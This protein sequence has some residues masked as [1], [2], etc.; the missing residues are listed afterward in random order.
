MRIT[1]SQAQR[2]SVLIS[3]LRWLRNTSLLALLATLFLLPGAQAATISPSSATLTSE[4]GAISSPSR[5]SL[6]STDPNQV[7]LFVAICAPTCDDEGSGSQADAVAFDSTQTGGSGTVAAI[8]NGGQFQVDFACSSPESCTV[9]V[10]FQGGSPGS[11]NAEVSYVTRSNDFGSSSTP[12]FISASA[13]L[14]GVSQLAP[15]EPRGLVQFDPTSYSVSE[16][17]ESVTVTAVREG[18]TNGEIVVEY[19][20]EDDSASAG[21]DYTEMSGTLTWPTGQGGRRTVTVPILADPDNE[22][23]DDEVFSVFLSEDSSDV[24]SLGQNTEARVTIVNVAPRPTGRIRFSAES[25]DARETDGTVTI[26]VQRVGGDR[27]EINIDYSTED[28]TAESGDDYEAASGELE[29]ANGDDS[30]RSFEVEILTDEEE[31]STEDFFVELSNEQRVRVNISDVPPD[32]PGSIQFSLDTYTVGE[33][34]GTV[35]LTAE[36]V[37]GSDG[38]LSVRFTTRD[39]SAESGDDYDA[40]NGTLT[41]D[42]GDDDP[43]TFEISILTDDGEEGTEDFFVDLSN[44]ESARVVIT[45][46]PP[47]N[48][49]FVEFSPVNYTALE[50]D[51][52]VTVT[53]TRQ[54]G[55]DGEITVVVTTVNGTAM[56]GSD[57]EAATDELTWLNG[58]AAP[59]SLTIELI[60][61]ENVE[62]T[63][64]FSVRMTLADEGESST[65]M[66]GNATTA[67]IEIEE[68]PVVDPGTL[69]FSSST[70]RAS[71]TDDTVDLIVTRTGGSDGAVAVNL[72]TSDGT[73][74]AGD[75]YE[76][77]Q[78]RLSW[79][80][81]ELGSKTLT[82]S[83]NEDTRSEPSETFTATLTLPSEQATST[84][85]TP[86]VATVTITDVAPPLE[87]GTVQFTTAAVSVDEDDDSVRLQISR[88]G[89]QDGAITMSVRSRNGSATEGEDFEFETVTVRWAD[90]DDGLRSVVVP[91]ELDNLDEPNETFRLSL[92]AD[93][94]NEQALGSPDTATVTIRDVSNPLEAGT[95]SLAEQSYQIREAQGTVTLAVNRTGGAQGAVSVQY[96]T[97]SG[98][99][100]SPEDFTESSGTL[101]WADGD[102]SP[103]QITVTV[104]ADAQ[105]EDDEQFEVTLS[106][107]E[108]PGN[109][110]LSLGRDSASVTIVDSTDPGQLQFTSETYSAG[111]S[112]GRVLFSVERIGGSDGPVSVAYQLREIT[113]SAGLDY[114]AVS[115]TLNWADGDMA[116]KTGAIQLLADREIETTETF[117]VILLNAQPVGDTQIVQ[118]LATMEIIDTTVPPND[119]SAV[120]YVLTIIS[121]DN[122]SFIPGDD[123]N[124]LVLQAS[125]EPPATDSVDNLAINWRVEPAGS[126][127]LLDGIQT[128]TGPDGQASNQVRVLDRGFVRVI[129][130]VGVATQSG[131]PDLLTGRIAPPAARLVDGEIAFT[132]RSGLLA[133]EGLNDNQSQTG[134][135]LDAACVA[136]DEQTGGQ[137]NNPIA[138][139]AAQLDLQSTCRALET[140]LADGTL[141]PALDRLAPEELFTLG[142]SVIDTTDLQITNVY[143]RINA[144]RSGRT[145]SVDVSGLSLDVRGELI[146]G[147]VVEAA[148][149]ALPSGGAASA[150]G[151]SGYGPRLGVFANGAL[152]VGEVDGD[153]NQRNADI[154]TTG[155]TIGLDYRVSANSVIGVGFGIA[156]NETEFTGDE[157]RID[158]SSFNVSLFATYY[159]ENSGYVD[160][161]LDAGRNQFDIERRIDLPG[162]TRRMARGS[163]DASVLAV[164]LGAGFDK[165]YGAIEFGPYARLSVVNAS[166]DAYEETADS[167]GQ[168]SGSVLSVASHS[169]RSTTASIGAQISRPVSTRSGVFVPQL[170]V[171]GEIEL[172][173]KKDG[174]KA[175]FQH[176]PTQTEFEVNGNPRD[177]SYLNI[178]LGSSFLF[179]SGRSGY[180][181]YETRAAHD[182]VT[183]HWLKLGLR[184]EF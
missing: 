70:Y 88:T 114:V 130:R 183:Q 103:K 127:E 24:S 132:L 85:G 116:A 28:G 175:T 104:A 22:D 71:E 179:A 168:G 110:N 108:G 23:D 59:K 133:A 91:I 178:G 16:D 163:T 117:E 151:L 123:L 162:T 165:N 126:A 63:E 98:S 68:T 128:V 21:S 6:R 17:G 8:D 140:R 120:P 34:D 58:D 50:S 131:S 29:W 97:S 40:G 174:I 62:P 181:F 106:N 52:E 87:T 101:R 74:D 45:D 157:G 137:T 149:N 99:A 82:V 113:A 146:P 180:V 122:Q 177:E 20:T 93:A 69:Q 145:D 51:G 118:G 13:Q 3:P 119:G 167:E 44:E 5:F 158:L 35:R 86:S 7:F 2:S 90:Q 160:V 37:D 144:I 41:W 49:G 102:S 65:G 81:G 26:T 171:E 25:Y 64:Q 36:R 53:A 129:A 12:D 100:E 96:D 156:N 79:T 27:G 150:D 4:D 61:D 164:T 89:G 54:Q 77:T 135:A 155:L 95:L 169:I 148:Q 121:G 43:Q 46:V 47:E 10:Q 48:S 134:G 14:I 19:G 18:G 147:S 30:P 184:L 124:P 73:A 115:G 84:L 111:E 143:S 55:S 31:E 105:V 42:D 60:E 92:I 112:D 159:E 182:F 39:G 136:L 166:V 9:D 78:G 56:A 107:P 94:A 15:P 33:N 57:F 153:D 109:A 83:L 170:R 72:S 142:D 161:V 80:D 172:V 75:D 141:A 1:P 67:T 138:L 76:A 173:D 11:Y 38:G 152:S 176:D 125:I 66:L 32:T 139:I 154:S